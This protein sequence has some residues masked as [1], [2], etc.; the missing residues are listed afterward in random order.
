MNGE[1]K[2]IT[3]FAVKQEK[4]M[5][6]EKAEIIAR[7]EDSEYKHSLVCEALET[8]LDAI[9]SSSFNHMY[10]SQRKAARQALDGIEHV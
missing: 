2:D 9:D 10:Y 7:L 4:L 8:L 5:K 1:F 6:K 3:R